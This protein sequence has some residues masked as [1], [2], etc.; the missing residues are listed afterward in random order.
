MDLGSLSPE[1]SRAKLGPSSSLESRHPEGKGSPTYIR[2][3]ELVSKLGWKAM[4]LHTDNSPLT[5]RHVSPRS[6]R[7]LLTDE[8]EGHCS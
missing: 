7:L 5:P 8:W 4:G 1:K 6:F 3:I 2:V